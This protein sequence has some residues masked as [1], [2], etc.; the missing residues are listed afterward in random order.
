MK[1]Y[2]SIAIISFFLASCGGGDDTPAPPPTAAENRAPNTPAQSAPTN[3]LLCMDNTV[4]FEWNAATDPDG[5]SVSY[6]LQIATNNAF[7]ENL[8]TKTTS[9]TSIT[10]IL[11]KGVAYY[12]RIRAKDNKN[13]SS[14]YSSTFNFYTEGDGQ[15]NHLPF[16]PAI[17][18]PELNSI[19]QTETVDL[20]WSASDV[21]NDALSFDVYFGIVNPPTEMIA[22]NI[23]ETS[24]NMTLEASKTYYW[25][26]VVKDGKGGTT[27]GQI[28]SFK[29]D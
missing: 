18:G 20:E 21:D 11:E 13:K 17:V 12:W 22:E 19:V 16:S 26:V 27:I 2:V 9:A 1:K 23:T 25:K 29:T 8:Q 24:I 15:S 10:V 4:T 5:D 14:G 7:T 28:W 3:N 6:E